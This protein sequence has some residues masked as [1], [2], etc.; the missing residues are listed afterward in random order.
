MPSYAGNM[1]DCSCKVNPISTLPCVHFS[2]DG[3]RQG[4]L[5]E[6]CWDLIQFGKW[7]GCVVRLTLYSRGCG[8]GRGQPCGILWAGKG[9]ICPINKQHR[10]YFGECGKW[11]FCW[12]DILTRGH[13]CSIQTVSSKISLYSCHVCRSTVQEV[14]RKKQRESLLPSLLLPQRAFA[15]LK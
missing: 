11:V 7:L 12:D 13:T 1:G 5:E 14:S 2:L 8:S 9:F 4:G 6:V 15:S 3:Q 10:N